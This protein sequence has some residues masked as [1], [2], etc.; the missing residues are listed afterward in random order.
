MTRR[1]D[2][3]SSHKMTRPSTP[4]G[5]IER[6]AWASE[7][8]TRVPGPLT[9][10]ARDLF[11]CYGAATAR[12]RVMPDFLVI[13][14]K[15]GGTTSVAN[16]LVR[17]PQVLPM[18]PRLQ[19]RKSPHYFDLNY[20]RGPAWYLS[21]F[22][23]GTARRLH[24]RR[25]GAAKV[26]EASPYYLFHPAA[27]A[28][29]RESCPDVRLIAILREPVSRAHS[30]YWDRVV[31]G[32][33]PVATFEEALD[34]EEARLT[35]VTSDWLQD[36]RHYSFSHDHHTYLARGRYA[37]QL[38]RYLRVFPRERLLVMPLD[39]LHRDPERS[40]R[41]IEEHLGLDH[42]VVDLESR[43]QR[44]DKPPLRDAT[45]ERLQEYYR[46]HNARLWE[47]LGEDFGW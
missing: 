35:G 32:N 43:N 22:P 11:R 40:F 36:P 39:A 42:R 13:G 34:V 2:E 24:A 27:P 15:K 18:F 30:N 4:I 33:E 44:E 19:R 46:P 8:R 5:G 41:R 45:R 37:E 38:E 28:R 20:W 1:V 47:L 21:H 7:A 9:D 3:A 16:W 29:I 17:H 23:S 25:T 14:T 31:T 6:A 12:L 26:G 10:L